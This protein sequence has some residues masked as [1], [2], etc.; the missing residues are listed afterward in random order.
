MKKIKRFLDQDDYVVQLSDDE[1]INVLGTK[2]SGKTTLSLPYIDRDDYIVVNCDRLLEL[3]SM[4]KEDSALSDIREMLTQKYGKENIEKE[5]ASCYLDVLQFIKSRH[6]KG[7]IEGNLIQDLSPKDLKGTVII[8]GTSSFKSFLRAV[9]RDYKNPYFMS[10][11]KEKHKYSYR[12]TRL[13]SIT[14]RRSNVFKQAKD[15]NETIKELE[16]N[17]VRK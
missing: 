2:G 15:I 17:K 14:K 12:I 4:E 3:P 10:L 7:F 16:N 8:K 1:I 6:K 11:E 5:F 13:I 9:K